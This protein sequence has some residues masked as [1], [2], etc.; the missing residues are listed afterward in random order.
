MTA[1]VVWAQGLCRF[2]QVPFKRVFRPL[3]R[4]VPRD[5]GVVTAYTDGR[6]TL[7]SNRRIDGYHEAAD[8]SGYQGVDVGDFVVHG[9]DI[10]R[11]SA[12]VSDSAG[13]ISAVCI[14]CIPRQ[15]IDSRYFGYV[16]RAQAFSGFPRAMARGVRE[17]GADFRRWDTLG[18]LPVPLPRLAEQRAIA[19][20]LDRELGRIQA[21][22]ESRRRIL[23][24]LAERRSGTT[25]EAIAECSEQDEWPLVKLKHVVR[26]FVDTL[27]ATAPEEDDG[28]GF[29]VGTACIKGGKLDLVMARRCS[30]ATLREWTKRAT[31]LPG[32]ILLTREA[33]AGEAALVPAGASIAAGQRVVLVRTDPTRMLPELVLYS[34]YSSRAS[35]FFRLLGRETTVAH[36][37]MAD[38][39][40]LPLIL[41][42]PDAQARLVQAI[43]SQLSR[44]DSAAA[45][46]T[47][48]IDLL[49]ER[50][51]ALITAAVMGQIEIPGVAA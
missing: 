2:P 12:G 8:L 18:E 35:R 46:M 45:A 10:L 7:R 32:D 31:P 34:I 11:G 21:T 5:A 27:H 22:I 47:S 26:G 17:G 37:N 50:R 20:Y 28:D 24:L 42:P 19:D 6:V 41:P 36:L 43:A 48:Q 29:I 9:L 30:V 1:S 44:I 39:G 4:P 3:S 23:D 25:D 15:D 40:E 14:V 33:P 16:I 38:I 49:L 13:A 51:Q